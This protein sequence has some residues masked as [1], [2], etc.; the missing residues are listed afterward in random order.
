MQI[1][2][3]DLYCIK[4]PTLQERCTLLQN[5]QCLKVNLL[6]HALYS[7]CCSCLLDPS[8]I[9][10]WSCVLEL[11][12]NNL[13]ILCTHGNCK[14]LPPSVKKTLESRLL[15]FV[16]FVHGSKQS[17]HRSNEP[18][19]QEILLFF[20]LWLWNNKSAWLFVC[21]WFCYCYFHLGLHASGVCG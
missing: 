16:V 19:E 10:F 15:G 6:L 18:F 12:K 1:F 4:P 7:R 8:S 9:M 17:N 20:P 3:Y 2:S 11:W 14:F 13:V 21:G 5:V